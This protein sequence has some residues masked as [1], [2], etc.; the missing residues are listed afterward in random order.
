MSRMAA[1][2]YSSVEKITATG[3]QLE[4]SALFRVA[5]G[6]QE[7]RD[8]W[9]QPGCEARLDAALRLNQRLWTLFQVELASDDNPLPAEI[10]LSLLRLIEYIDRRTFDV[11]ASP[12][13]EKLGILIRINRNI[14]AGLAAQPAR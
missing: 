11:V 13:P 2:A 14:A 6:L 9:G 4:A 5:R 3:R 12:Q 7:V 10:K 8:G 1:E